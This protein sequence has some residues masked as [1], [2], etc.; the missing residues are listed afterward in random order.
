MNDARNAIP[1]IA[2]NTILF[3]EFCRFCYVLTEGLAG[4]GDE[5]FRRRLIAARDRRRNRGR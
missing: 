5:V 2:W 4:N 3:E 1:I